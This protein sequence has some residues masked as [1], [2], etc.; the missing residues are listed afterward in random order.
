M[1]FLLELN[2]SRNQM[3]YREFGDRGPLVFVIVQ[4]Y[5]FVMKIFVQNNCVTEIMSS[6]KSII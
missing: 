4:K 2:L 5:L 3:F 6:E 1:L